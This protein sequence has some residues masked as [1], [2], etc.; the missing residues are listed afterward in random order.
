MDDEVLHSLIQLIYEAAIDP[1]K[2]S[3]FLRK[4][5]EAAGAQ[6]IAVVVHNLA[7]QSGSIEANI[8]FD[9]ESLRIYQ[10]HYAARNPWVARSEHL[11]VPGNVVN[12]D[13]LIAPQELTPTLPFFGI[14]GA[15][16]AFARHAAIRHVAL[17]PRSYQLS[18]PYYTLVAKGMTL[19]S[20]R[21]Q[22][23]RNSRS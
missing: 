22:I 18:S 5:A 23:V 9:P 20:G 11:F 17:L 1:D 16:H 12:C 7:G 4:W 21:R 6:G 3:V 13:D 2:W 10:N 8:G 19:P 14:A 15:K